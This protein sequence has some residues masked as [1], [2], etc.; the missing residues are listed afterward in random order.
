MQITEDNE[1][2]ESP[3]EDACQACTV[4]PCIRC[5]EPESSDPEIQAFDECRGIPSDGV[6]G[7]VCGMCIIDDLCARDD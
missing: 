1:R 4:N 7:R 6:V 2:I 3:I 5:G